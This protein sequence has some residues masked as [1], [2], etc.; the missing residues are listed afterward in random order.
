MADVDPFAQ[1]Q[2]YTPR[3]TDVVDAIFETKRVTEAALRA[4]PLRNARVDDGLMVWRGNYAG[5][6]GI[7]DSYLWIGEVSPN[8]GVLN[9]QQ[10]GFFLTRDDPKHAPALWMYDP[11]AESANPIN[12]PLRQ[13]IY[14]KDAD[15]RPIMVESDKGGTE[16]P[17]GQVPLY[18]ARVDNYVNV[19]VDSGTAMK[20]IP[21]LGPN[22]VRGGGMYTMFR[23]YGPMVGNRLKAWL[24]GFTSSGSA[25]GGS[26]GLH[27]RLNWNDNSAE[28][29]SGRITCPANGGSAS[30][31]WDI[32]FA[33]QN[34][35]GTEVNVQ[36]MCELLSGSDEWAYAYPIMCYS[37][38][39]G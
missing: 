23:G 33:G 7:S 31:F 34:K 2:Q 1:A 11:S 36:V 10:R 14:I 30:F 17:Y 29:N 4:N 8:D 21:A 6:G 5:Q 20:F 13:K 38:G 27:L 28:F 12:K 26:F 9:K 15:D 18:G 39:G 37:Y 35:V 16:F 32:D 24:F 25:V 22:V 19:R 3:Q